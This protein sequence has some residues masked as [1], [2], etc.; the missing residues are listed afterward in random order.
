MAS[1][2]SCE[3][4]MKNKGNIRKIMSWL[5]TLVLWFGSLAPA[6]NAFAKEEESFQEVTWE[7]KEMNLHRIKVDDVET[8]MFR[9]R[10]KKT[11]EEKKGYCLDFDV[12]AKFTDYHSYPVEDL[13]HLEQEF[14]AVKVKT[15]MHYGYNGKN[16]NEIK[17]AVGENLTEAE[18]VRAT[19]L[20]LWSM[21]AKKYNVVVRDHARNKLQL[22]NRGNKQIETHFGRDEQEDA[23]IY[24]LY[25][26]LMKKENIPTSTQL[27]VSMKVDNL[28]VDLSEATPVLTYDIVLNGAGVSQLDKINATVK[29]G[30]N[31]IAS[32]TNEFTSLTEGTE[33]VRVT[34]DGYTKETVQNKVFKVALSSLQTF[35]DYLGMRYLTAEGISNP[36]GAQTIIIAEK[37]EGSE[38][39]KATAEIEVKPVEKEVIFSKVAAGQTQELEG[40]TLTVKDAQDKV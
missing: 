32:G 8:M 33:Q 28:R 38:K 22:W 40:A 1:K 12:E 26:Y 11:G 35:V 31:T 24:K 4:Y 20:A 7:M 27:P 29:E 18:A 19:Q 34:L 39:I 9:L 37:T 23:R 21:T 30:S 14:D 15:I 36:M 17:S 3:G 13:N 2:I 10:N 16:L 5:L 25:D 6:T